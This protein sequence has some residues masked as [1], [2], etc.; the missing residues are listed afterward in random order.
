MIKISSFSKSFFMT[1]RRRKN[2]LFKAEK[3][4]NWGKNSLEVVGCGS[5]DERP[6]PTRAVADQ[7]SI[8]MTI[9]MIMLLTVTINNHNDDNDICIHVC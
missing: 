2:T 1:K 5:G 8:M 7:K 4:V 3:G 6:K 9:S